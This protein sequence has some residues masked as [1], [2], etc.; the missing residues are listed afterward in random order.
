[1]K[2]PTFLFHFLMVVFA[3][4]FIGLGGCNNDPDTD[5]IGNWVK[6][7]PLDG[8]SRSD[9]VGF[10][11]GDKGYVGTGYDGDDRL[12]DFWE[13]DP[14]RNS[15]TQRADLPGDVRNSA[16]GCGTDTKGYI[17][18][19]YNGISKL[20][21]F[22][23]YDP[24]TNKWTQKADFS[25][26]IRIGAVA[27]SIDN[28]V[29]IGSGYDGHYLKDFW[30]Y[31]PDSDT[32]A[33]VSGFGGEKREDAVAFVIDRKAYVCTGINSGT[34]EDDFWVYDPDTDSWTQKRDIANTSNDSYDNKYTSIVGSNKV[35]FTVN[36]KG[37]VAT[38]GQ[39]TTG[40]NVWEYDPVNDLW[41]AKTAFEGAARYEAVGFAIGSRGYVTTGRTSS[42][43]MEDLWAFDP[44][45]DYNEDD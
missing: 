40:T 15:W 23:E 45:A 19:G 31:D 14:T 21:D 26:G 9:A 24:Q 30:K 39:G 42:L 2:K 3:G 10:S 43:Y 5:L 32:W 12:N 11:I 18:T 7:S 1:M 28:K 34:Y 36:G 8:V 17:G 41:T 35:A 20:N 37:Y 6:L 4:V 22:W 16:V 38:G 44:D 33:Q 25:G 29:Y 27:F 13:Y